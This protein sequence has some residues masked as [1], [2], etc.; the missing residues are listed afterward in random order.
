MFCHETR[1]KFESSFFVNS[2][3]QVT[4]L[5]AIH[6]TGAKRGKTRLAYDWFRKW[7]EF[8][9]PIRER[10]KVKPK[11]TQI[12]FDTQLKTALV[13][14]IILLCIFQPLHT[15]VLHC[16]VV[17]LALEVHHQ[18]RGVWGR[19][20]GIPYQEKDGIV[21]HPMGCYGVCAERCSFLPPIVD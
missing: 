2:Y 17:T 4:E 6:V 20:K 9:E 21:F 3:M 12:I 11:Q 1:W 14:L 13:R 18:K 7:R 15:F 8:L 10:S 19:G 5:E 16:L